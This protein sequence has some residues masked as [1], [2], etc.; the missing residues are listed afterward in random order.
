MTISGTPRL[1]IDE[2]AGVEAVGALHV[3]DVGLAVGR[4]GLA[5][6]GELG[7]ERGDA[8]RRTI[9]ASAATVRRGSCGSRGLVDAFL[10]LGRRFLTRRHRSARPSHANHH[11]R[12]PPSTCSRRRAGSPCRRRSRK[13]RAAAH[14]PA[15]GGS[16][17]ADTGR[18]V[19]AGSRCRP[20]SASPRRCAAP[21]ASTVS[22]F[23]AASFLSPIALRAAAGPSVALPS[24]S[25]RTPSET[26]STSPEHAGHEGFGCSF[27]SPEAKTTSRTGGFRLQAE[28]SGC[29]ALNGRF[30]Q[31]S[32]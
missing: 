2:Q 26:A 30:T 29:R 19:P 23:S 16:K 11:R 18:A 31:P 8:P 1:A 32:G 15:G 7:V 3:D 6:I 12:R 27:L 10:L 20:P 5:G 9:P 4:L 24:P 17:R 25:A 28:G 21:C 22:V 14:R 13:V